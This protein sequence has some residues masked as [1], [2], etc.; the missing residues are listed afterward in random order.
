MSSYVILDNL[1]SAHNVGSVF[2]TCDAAG[3]EKVLL[4]GTTPQP[5]DRFGRKRSDIAKVALG[6]EADVPYEY[7]QDTNE[8]ILSLKFLGAQIVAIEQTEHAV[9]YKTLKPNEHVAYVF[10]NEVDGLSETTMSQCDAV[11]VIPM[12][13]NKESLNVAVCVGVVLFR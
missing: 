13:G 1:R 5:F 4:C 8:A 12:H 3:V 6:A 7:F 9:D 11:A 10:G 2:R